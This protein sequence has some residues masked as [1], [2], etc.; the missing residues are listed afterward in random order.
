[1]VGFA[2]YGTRAEG[3][4]KP[5]RR[6][7]NCGGLGG[8][9][10]RHVILSDDAWKF[11]NDPFPAFRA[12]LVY[13]MNKSDRQFLPVKDV[14]PV[15][16]YT[17]TADYGRTALFV[18]TDRATAEAAKAKYDA[19]QKAKAG[20]S[21]YWTPTADLKA[22]LPTLPEGKFRVIKTKEKGTILVVPG[23]DDS[24]RCLLFVG[25]R[26][27]FRGGVSVIDT[28]G[29]ILK[30]CSAGNACESSTEVIVLLEAGQSIVFHS[31]GRRTDEVFQY[32]WDCREVKTLHFSKAEWD[33]RAAVSVSAA[34]GEA[35]VL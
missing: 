14:V 25:G 16:Q 35:E 33:S 7:V 29:T 1:M 23:N 15:T 2:S 10:M 11:G 30:E 21:S 34:K 32:L 12:T 24:N 13:G 18:G 17:V 9:K 27:G 20:S 8:R 26:G 31:Y 5:T 3:N 6:R 22:G 19:E 28:T 4:K